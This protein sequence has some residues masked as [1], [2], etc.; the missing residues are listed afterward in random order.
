MGKI[1]QEKEIPTGYTSTQAD[2]SLPVENVDTSL[3]SVAA[4]LQKAYPDPLLQHC[5][6]QANKMEVT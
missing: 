5:S 1:S 2:Y 6:C 4:D 3:I